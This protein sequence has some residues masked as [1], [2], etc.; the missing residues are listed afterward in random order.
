MDIFSSLVALRAVLLQFPVKNTMVGFPGGTVDKSTCQCQGDIGSI[1]GLGGF[2]MPVEQLSWWTTAT[3]PMHPRACA[4]QKKS[5]PG[6]PQLEKSPWAAMKAQ[7]SQKKKK[8]ISRN[9]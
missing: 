1:P 3:E 4:L 8:K 5:S 7:H 9:V 6:W 2:H